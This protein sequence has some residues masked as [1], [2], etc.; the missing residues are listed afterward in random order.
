MFPILKH[1]YNALL[2]ALILIIFIVVLKWSMRHIIHP[3]NYDHCLHIVF[4]IF[5]FDFGGLVLVNSVWL[6]YVLICFF[7]L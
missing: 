3:A 2:Q 4:F 5:L 1:F 7:N 6:Y